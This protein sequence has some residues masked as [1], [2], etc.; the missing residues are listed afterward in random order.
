[1]YL[2]CIHR[3]MPELLHCPYRS[4]RVGAGVAPLDCLAKPIRGH[5]VHLHIIKGGIRH[6]RLQHQCVTRSA[7]QGTRA[8][9]GMNSFARRA[10]VTSR[11]WLS[12]CSVANSVADAMGPKCVGVSAPTC[13]VVHT[14]II[15][16]R[17]ACV[18]NHMKPSPMVL[19][20]IELKTCMTT[21]SGTAAH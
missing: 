10:N 11:S 17:N 5:G 14:H 13:F 1:M 15:S 6:V 12:V 9:C 19:D 21:S 16:G 2:Y 20:E 8:I 3:Y 7:S 4:R 18:R